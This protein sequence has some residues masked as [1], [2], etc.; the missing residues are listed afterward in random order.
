MSNHSIVGVL[1]ARPDGATSVALGLAARLSAHRRVITIDLSLH[2][3][4]VA[5]LLNL[6]ESAGVHRLA[7]RSRLAGV[8]G[9]DLSGHL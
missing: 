2:R 1:S 6:D 9:A 5:A 8:T 4:E 3:P 7:S